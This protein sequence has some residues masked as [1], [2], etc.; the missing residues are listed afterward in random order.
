MSSAF[1]QASKSYFGLA[2]TDILSANWHTVDGRMVLT[3]ELLPT[4]DDMI[5]I[6]ERMKQMRDTRPVPAVTEP[7]T[8]QDLEKVE[9]D[10]GAEYD[11][12]TA[13]ERA[14]YG[15]R[16]K[17]IE[18]R[19]AEALN[20]GRTEQTQGIGGRKVSHVDAPETA[21]PELPDAVWVW[22]SDVT[23]QQKALSSSYS[24]DRDSFLVQTVMLTPEQ[25]VKYGVKP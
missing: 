16:W 3:F 21:A 24:I 17:Y 9:R 7:H 2:E 18:A 12:M 8:M 5:G 25:T 13:S 10:A 4:D 19:V 23:D 20:V 14:P 11:R 22:A 6:A 1:I 15:A